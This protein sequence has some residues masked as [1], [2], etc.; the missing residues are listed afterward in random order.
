MWKSNMFTTCTHDEDK[1]IPG[2]NYWGIL[3][4]MWNSGCESEKECKVLTSTINVPSSL[5]RNIFPLLL[6]HHPFLSG[7]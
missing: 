1:I 2:Q 5:P 3:E 4:A 7:L 6:K